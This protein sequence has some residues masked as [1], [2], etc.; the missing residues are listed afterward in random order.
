MLYLVGELP[1]EMRAGAIRT[2]QQHAVDSRRG[3]VVLISR[4]FVGGF[5][6][7]VLY[8]MQLSERPWHGVVS[9]G[10]G[11]RVGCGLGYL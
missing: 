2:V 5:P 6:T 8:V 11:A 1:R 10:C 7:T 4:A 3:D 9:S